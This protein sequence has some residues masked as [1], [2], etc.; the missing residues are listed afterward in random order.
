MVINYDIPW[1]PVRV[2][3]RLG[4]INR[5]SKKVFEKLFI[6]NFFPTEKG[7]QLVKSR[8][9]AQTKMFMI[10]NTLGEDSKIFD[11]DE[12]P[13]PAKL[14]QKLL[15]NPE[16][17]E[18]ESFYTKVLNLFEDIKNKYPDLVKSLEQM[19]KRI[20]VTKQFNE[21]EMIVC[22]MKNRM[23]IKTVKMN[24]GKAEVTDSSL[25]LVLEKI[26]CN[27]DEK[28]LQLD[29]DF[30]KM[31]MQAKETKERVY[32]PTSA[33]SIEKKALINMIIFFV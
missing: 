32:N 4:R 25:E 20:K 6:V 8:E 5:I 31:Y 18:E 1:N 16:E 11:P 22:F 15:Q 24:D 27:P 26:K 29:D 3:Q 2:I 10:H 19:P 17:N 7:A 13:S 9:I 33:Q 21:D 14:Y 23:Y 30:W 12:E 28:N